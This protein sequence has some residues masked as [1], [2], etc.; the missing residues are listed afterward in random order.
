MSSSV[1]LMVVL[2]VGLCVVGCSGGDESYT[3]ME[4]TEWGELVVRR[5]Y[6]SGGGGGGGG[7]NK[8]EGGRGRKK[9]REE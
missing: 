2:G 3:G 5:G 1:M 8:R 7:G 4:N 9:E 6:G